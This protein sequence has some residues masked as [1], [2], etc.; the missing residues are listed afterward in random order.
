M[1]VLPTWYASF[2]PGIFLELYNTFFLKF[3]MVLKVHMKLCVTELDFWE[4]NFFA[5]KLRK[6]VKM[7]Q[8]H[9]FFNLLENLVINFL[10][11]LIYNRNLYYLLCSCTNPIFGK[12]F[13]PEIWPKCSQPM[14]LQDFL[15]NYI[16]RTNQWNS[17][18][19]CML[20]QIYIT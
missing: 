14:R 6:R 4:K 17:P 12:V 20:M 3:D 15:I 11:N 16:S 19:F 9:G 10:L 8:K 5:P 7:G 2:C 18:S 1:S 13:V